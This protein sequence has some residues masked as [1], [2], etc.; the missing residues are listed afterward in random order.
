MTVGKFQGRK[1]RDDIL[2][3]MEDAVT[4]AFEL[5]AESIGVNAEDASRQTWII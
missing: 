4:A 2:K 5:G 3:M 1:T